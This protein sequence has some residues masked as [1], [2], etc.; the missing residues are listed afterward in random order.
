MFPAAFDADDLAAHLLVRGFHAEQQGGLGT[1]QQPPLLLNQVPKFFGCPG[2]SATPS[3]SSAMSR[4]SS[5]YGPATG[6]PC[7]NRARRCTGFPCEQGVGKV[8]RGWLAFGVA[9][10]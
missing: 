8:L 3:G 5:A 9:V 6:R 7:R 1:A 10:P 4:A 2:H